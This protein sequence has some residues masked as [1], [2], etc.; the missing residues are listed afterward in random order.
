MRKYVQRGAVSSKVRYE[1]LRNSIWEEVLSLDRQM[2]TIHDRDIQEIAMIKAKEFG[3]H[4][5]VVRAQ[6]FFY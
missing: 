4:E 6:P 5:F 3:L 1:K 2:I